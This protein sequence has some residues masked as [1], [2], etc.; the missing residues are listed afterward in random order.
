MRHHLWSRVKQRQRDSRSRIMTKDKGIRSERARRPSYLLSGL[1][2]C[3]TCGGG[4]S[5][6]S[7]SQYGCSTARNKGTVTTCL[8]C[9]ETTW[10]PR[11]WMA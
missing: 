2:K 11:S 8:R 1:L 6:I 10:K 3:G 9:G 4:F 7:L 5:K